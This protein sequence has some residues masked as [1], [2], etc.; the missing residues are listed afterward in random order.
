MREMYGLGDRPT[1]SEATADAPTE[2]AADIG[3]RDPNGLTVLAR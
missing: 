2:T 1:T 3:R